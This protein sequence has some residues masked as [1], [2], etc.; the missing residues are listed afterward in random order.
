ML[1][2][3]NQSCL[4]FSDQSYLLPI[5][6]WQTRH[7]SCSSTTTLFSCCK[8]IRLWWT[9]RRWAS[10]RFRNICR[11]WR[12]INSWL[13]VDCRNGSIAMTGIVCG[14]SLMALKGFIFV[15]CLVNNWTADWMLASSL[16]RLGV[17]SSLGWFKGGIDR[18]K[19]NSVRNTWKKYLIEKLFRIS[20]ESHK[21]PFE[22]R[23]H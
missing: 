22:I 18:Y 23:F 14:S 9:W 11:E 16:L 12:S 4:I 15:E 19:S 10:I 6:F 20:D 13:T 7:M 8:R 21:N 2:K 17:V 5:R 3:T 1:L